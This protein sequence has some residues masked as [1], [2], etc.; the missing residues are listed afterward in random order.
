MIQYIVHDEADSVGVVVVEGVK[1]GQELTGWVMEQD[2][3]ISCFPK[4]LLLWLII[5]GAWLLPFPAFAEKT[6]ITVA[7]QTG[8]GYIPMMVMEKERLIE[9][10]AKKEGLGDIKVN[11]THLA[12]GATMNDALLANALDFAAGGLSPAILLWNKSRGGAKM[13]AA[14]CTMPEKLTTRNPNVRSIKDLT[15]KDKIAMPAV[16]VSDQARFLQMAAAEAFGESNY[17]RLDSLTVTMSHPDGYIA[18]TSGLSIDAHFTVSPFADEEAKLPD[19]RTI[20]T[21]YDVIGGPITATVIWTTKKFHDEN[22]K[23]YSAFLDA[24]NEGIDIVNADKQAAAKLYVNFTKSKLSQ[25]EI[26][27]IITQ[28]GFYYSTTPHN[29]DK[30]VKFLHKVGAVQINVADQKDL[31]FTEVFKA[32]KSHPDANVSR[33]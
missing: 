14:V 11:W 25:E 6:A 29:V 2:K 26:Y 17:H 18:L 22:P 33:R 8:V 28:P 5:I 15:S 16:G 31:F 3:T 7:E 9:K 30:L 1:A 12:G 20:L 27:N 23:I 13:V 32:S 21:S 4:A 19:A 10:Y 24:L